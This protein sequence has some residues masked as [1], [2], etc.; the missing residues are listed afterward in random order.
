VSALAALDLVVEE[1]GS[2]GIVFSGSRSL[3]DAVRGY[4]ASTG[5]A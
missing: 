1:G 5:S 4:I 3:F 2:A